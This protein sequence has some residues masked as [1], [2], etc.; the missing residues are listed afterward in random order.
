MPPLL[1]LLLPFLPRPLP[2]LS[3]KCRPMQN[4]RQVRRLALCMRRQNHLPR[5]SLPLQPLQPPPR[6]EP[7]RQ[8]IARMLTL[9]HRSRRLH[10]LRWL[11][12]RRQRRP[13][14]YG[15]RNRQATRKPAPRKPA[16]KRP[17]Q[18]RF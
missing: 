4:C 3:I 15:L 16:L 18:N 9:P 17:Q 13:L 5:H 14:R 11:R 8:C 2:M 6:R 12:P 10:P 7:L 1:L